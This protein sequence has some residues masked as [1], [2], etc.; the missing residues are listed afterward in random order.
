MCICLS[1][2]TKIFQLFASVLNVYMP[3][4]VC[5]TCM[6]AVSFLRLS[7]SLSLFPACMHAYIRCIHI[8]K[9]AHACMHAYIHT[10]IH[11]PKL[12]DFDR[13]THTLYRRLRFRQLIL[14]LSIHC[15][16]CVTCM[17]AVSFLRLSK[18][19]RGYV[20][21]YV[22]VCMRYVCVTCMD[23]ISFLRLSKSLSKSLF[24]I[25]PAS[26]RR[27]RFSERSA[28]L[29]MYVCMY[30]CMCI[31]REYAAKTFGAR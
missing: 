21:V 12:R 27:R 10:C 8:P 9:L 19:L 16:A 18:S 24:P 13:R 1:T 6:D 30:V 25:R 5:V 23:A 11:I 29:R 28:S 26:P 17:D 31:S 15:Y 22:R 20:C 7:K 3:R 14:I 2:N 4:Y